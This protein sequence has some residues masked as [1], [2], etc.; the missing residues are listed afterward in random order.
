MYTCKHT[1]VH[2]WAW[3]VGV[4]MVIVFTLELLNIIHPTMYLV[5]QLFSYIHPHI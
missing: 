5:P 2:M 1:C 3:L 4:A